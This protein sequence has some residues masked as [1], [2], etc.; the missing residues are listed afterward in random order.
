VGCATLGFAVAREDIR[1]EALAKLKILRHPPASA[2]VSA[3]INNP[4]NTMEK[5][6][7][8][9]EYMSNI[10]GTTLRTILVVLL[11]PYAFVDISPLGLQLLQMNGFIPAQD[12]GCEQWIMVKPSECYLS[13]EKDTQSFHSKLFIFID[14][15]ARA[16]YFLASCGV[17]MIPSIDDIAKMLIKKP[18]SFLESSGGPVQLVLRDNVYIRDG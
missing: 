13:Q 8:I 3:L 2:V 15:G 14:F 10:Q 11:T 4:P 1:E 7:E 9:F 16:N 6:K 17:K 12:P 5:A 18:Q